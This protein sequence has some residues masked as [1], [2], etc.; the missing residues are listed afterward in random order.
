[1]PSPLPRDTWALSGEWTFRRDCVTAGERGA[2]LAVRFHARDLHLVMAPIDRSTPV[3][4]QV[5]LDGRPPGAAHGLDIDEGGA[6]TIVEPRMYQLI[7]QD[8]PI[9]D[10]T[11]EITLPD[12]GAA[13]FV[14]TF[15]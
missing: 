13:A 4:F 5:R 15:G 12:G 14:V 3:R 9:V 1:M 7:R 8:R 10:R 6:G 2:G 11:A